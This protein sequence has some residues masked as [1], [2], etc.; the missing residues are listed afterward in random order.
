MILLGK[1]SL[2]FLKGP[3]GEA[4]VVA[5]DP[6]KELVVV[7]DQ[8]GEPGTRNRVLCAVGISLAK[9]FGA[10]IHAAFMRETYRAVKG[11]LPLTTR[12]SGKVGF[13]HGL[14]A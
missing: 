13:P 12:L 10:Q 5:F 1:K 2:E 7:H 8:S 4:A 14:S 11:K 6:V 3:V 9:Q